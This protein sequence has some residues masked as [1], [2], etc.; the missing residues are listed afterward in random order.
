MW[1]Y[2][3]VPAERAAA[4]GAGKR[5]SLTDGHVMKSMKPR[6]GS[7]QSSSEIKDLVVFDI[8]RDSKCAE[9]FQELWKGDFL[10]MEG[11]RPLCLSCADLD[12][13]LYLP[14]GDTALTRR[15][16]KHSA[17]SAVVVRFS[18]S[19]GR[20]ERQGVLIEEPALE[21]AEEECRADAAE[22]R[23][24]RERDRLLRAKQDRDLTALMIERII[25]LFPACPPEEARAIA[26][27]TSV[28]GSGRV[29]RT[30]A[31]RAL[32]EDALTA[33]VIAAIRHKHTP[34]DRL[35]CAVTAA[36]MHVTPSARRWIV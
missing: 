7:Q 10:F 21:R 15:A 3:Y 16:R 20:Y 25:K 28:R 31:G 32:Q 4:N 34:Y 29:G 23:A 2:F 30:S 5:T 14:R 22:R 17:L 12:H 35:G 27:H 36:G 18:R 24:K 13:L 8:L 1:S 19:R 6:E 11:Q 9:C 26:A 33:A